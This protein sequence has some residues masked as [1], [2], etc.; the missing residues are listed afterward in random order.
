VRCEGSDITLDGG[1]AQ[2]APGWSVRMESGGPAEVEVAFEMHSEAVLVVSACVQGSPRFQQD[3]IESGHQGDPSHGGRHGSGNPPNASGPI[4]VT[5]TSSVALV[6]AASTNDPQASDAFAVSEPATPTPVDPASGTGCPTDSNGVPGS[7]QAPGFTGT[8]GDTGAEATAETTTGPTVPPVPDG[9]PSP[10]S[11]DPRS[12]S[13]IT[14][15]NSE[16]GHDVV[17]APGC[18][19]ASSDSGAVSPSP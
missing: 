8:A 17:S 7:D 9:S 11:T 12:G 6:A 3:R 4:A 10:A 16:S 13:P 14:L 2:P 5:Q 18:R 1:F 15:S 19:P